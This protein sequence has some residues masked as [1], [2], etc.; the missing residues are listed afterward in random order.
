MHKNIDSKKILTFCFVLKNTAMW[1]IDAIVVSY[2]KLNLV[3]I[4]I[5]FKITTC[6]QVQ[7]DLV[8]YVQLKVKSATTTAHEPFPL[9]Y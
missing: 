4:D 8:L 1:S 2:P 7:R 6:A 3:D 9:N 5:A